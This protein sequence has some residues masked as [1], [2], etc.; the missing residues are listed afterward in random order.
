MSFDEI[1]SDDILL[2][3]GDDSGGTTELMLRLL[4]TKSDGVI[5]ITLD[6]TADEILTEIRK[7]H[8]G[9]P[10]NEVSI[11]D[12]SD[13]EP[14]ADPPADATVIPVDSALNMTKIGVEFTNA[15]GEL[16]ENPDID[17]IGVGFHSLSRLIRDVDVKP[18]YQFFQVLTGQ[19]RTAEAFGVAVLETDK[20]ER[21]DYRLFYH[22]FD[23]VLQIR[24]SEDG[25]KEFQKRGLSPQWSDWKQF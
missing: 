17:H 24:Q 18:V 9:I 5:I 21:D 15:F 1:S 23:G 22:H 3:T 20:T 25:T 14:R 4:A 8:D 10:S 16:H 19:I 13:E 7:Y 6:N 12:C 11:I 2:V